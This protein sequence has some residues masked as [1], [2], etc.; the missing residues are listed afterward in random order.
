[1]SDI[2]VRSRDGKRLRTWRPV[3][4]V[5]EHL[6]RRGPANVDESGDWPRFDPAIAIKE[7]EAGY[8]VRLAAPGVSADDLEVIGS[9]NRLFIQGRRRPP[10]EPNKDAASS[11]ELGYG[12]FRRT[13]VITDPSWDGQAEATL[14]RGVLTIL[15]P[16]AGKTRARRGLG[17]S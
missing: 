4:W 15:I 6:G 16:S 12:F 5:R 7:V 17:P 9:G 8:E 10:R 1:M 3:G 11:R 14:D 13:V 2:E